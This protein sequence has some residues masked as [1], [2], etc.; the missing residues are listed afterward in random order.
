MKQYIVMSGSKRIGVAYYYEAAA[1]LMTLLSNTMT[2]LRIQPV[3]R[4]V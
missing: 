1:A 3:I 4:R 2:N